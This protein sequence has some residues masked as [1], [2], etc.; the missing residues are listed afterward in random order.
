MIHFM[1]SHIC[2][3]ISRLTLKMLL[4][5]RDLDHGEAWSDY[6]VLFA[7]SQVPEYRKGFNNLLHTIQVHCI[8]SSVPMVCNDMDT[9]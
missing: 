1:T 9:V 7:N 2:P 4:N 6:N 3:N 5:I 8:E